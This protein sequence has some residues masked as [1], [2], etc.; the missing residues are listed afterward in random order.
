MTCIAAITEHGETWIGSDS[1]CILGDSY[2]L[3]PNPYD[4]ILTYH[5]DMPNRPDLFIGVAGTICIQNV[6]QYLL[7]SPEFKF[8]TI[9]TLV[10]EIKRL[11]F[12]EKL[13]LKN[14]CE[15][16]YVMEGE[17]L[18]IHAHIMYHVD[19]GFGYS[20]YKS[21][22]AVIGETI[23][24]QTAL[25]AFYALSTNP[26]E[27]MPPREKL[28]LALEAAE[29]NSIYVRKPF[30]IKQYSVAGEEKNSEIFIENKDRIRLGW[31]PQ[32]TFKKETTRIE[33]EEK[34]D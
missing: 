17:L 25:G 6:I 21:N 20:R 15:E 1:I 27:V 10:Q 22:Y 2:R 12:E 7:N 5:I 34:G 29:A 26:C 13:Y 3:T 32:K 18:I 23:G 9:S 11:C 19:S 28:L 31:N 30:G 33:E 14:H 16:S 8:T 4:K 24:Q